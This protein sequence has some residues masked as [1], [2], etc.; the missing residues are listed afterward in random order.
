M[1]RNDSLHH[2]FGSAIR[3]PLLLIACTSITLL[4]FFW[5]DYTHIYIRVLDPGDRWEL[6]SSRYKMLV[7]RLPKV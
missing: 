6:R 1:R 5:S 7:V 3:W 2:I 4:L